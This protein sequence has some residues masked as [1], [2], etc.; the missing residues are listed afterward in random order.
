MDKDNQDSY[1]ILPAI[2]K[3]KDATATSHTTDLAY[4][5]VYDGHGKHGHHCSWFVRDNVSSI[6]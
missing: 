5:A 4:F 3:K 2:T 6:L 1:T